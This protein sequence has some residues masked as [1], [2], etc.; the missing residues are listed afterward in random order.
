ML[1]LTLD[2][3][4]FCIENNPRDPFV[5]NL[6]EH[7]YVCILRH[8]NQNSIALSEFPCKETTLN[9]ITVFFLKKLFLLVECTNQH[10]KF[11]NG[12]KKIITL[13]VA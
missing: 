10:I 8:K 2:E 6:P 7:N 3:N 4:C 9:L 5:Y 13:A 1:V 11:K 12:E